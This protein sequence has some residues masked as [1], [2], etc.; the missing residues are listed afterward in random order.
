MSKNYNSALQSNNTDLQAILNIV[1][2]LP[3][4]VEQATPIINVN[5][6]GLITATA[7]TKSSTHQ[8]AFQAAKTIT[9]TTTSQIAVSSGYYTG[10]A[11]MVKGDANLVAGNIKSGV[12]IFGVNGNYAG[13]GGDAS[14]EDALVTRNLTSYT[15]DRIT[16][17]G[18]FAF[19]GYNKL[20][21]VNFPKV[22]TIGSSAFMWCSSLATVSFPLAT[23]INMCAFSSCRSLV[24]VSFPKVTTIGTNAF[25]SCSGLTT[26][27]FPVATTIADYAFSNCS[28]LAVA[29]FPAA[30]SVESS[31]FRGCFKLSIVDL[32]AAKSIYNNAFVSCSSLATVRLSNAINIYS[33]AFAGCYNLKSLYLAGSSVCKLSASNAFSSTPIGGYSTSAKTYGSIY[34]PAS[35]LASYKTATNWTYFSSRFV[36]I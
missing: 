5:S 3:E 2:E 35:L 31:A 6:S 29:S 20:T 4:A 9:P 26:I 14:V 34:V 33:Y 10:G 32:P 22:T 18:S 15:N 17:I 25:T 11:V 13:S 23:T 30:I 16:S 12:S 21:T 24:T 27:S 1:N 36:G 8:L 28:K 7:G 19:Y